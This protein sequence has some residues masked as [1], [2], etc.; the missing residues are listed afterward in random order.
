MDIGAH[1]SIAGGFYKCIERAGALGANCLQTF[2]SSPR[3][4]SVSAYSSEELERYKEVKSSAQMGPHF[5]H[6]VYL[7]NLAS[8]KKAYVHASVDSLIFYQQLAG[9]IGGAG[10]IFH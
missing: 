8:E 3:S 10:T 2:A 5:F 1:V 4:L 9:K 6:G 7:V